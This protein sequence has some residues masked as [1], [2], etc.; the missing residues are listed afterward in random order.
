MPP[1]VATW[2][3]WIAVFACAVG[4][5]AIL[6][7]TVGSRSP[8]DPHPETDLDKAASPPMVRQPAPGRLHAVG[9]VIWAVLP[10]VGLALVLL[11]TWNVMHADRRVAIRSDPGAAA[12]MPALLGAPTPARTPVPAIGSR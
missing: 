5:V 4:Q 10:G 9:E 6:R 12:A 11:W 7:D 8:A 3:F 2:S 1:S